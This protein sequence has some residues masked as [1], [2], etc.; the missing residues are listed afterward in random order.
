M[1]VSHVIALNQGGSEAMT[2][3]S[4]SHI[5]DEDQSRV[6]SEQN[7]AIWFKIT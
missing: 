5:Q 1:A 7:H 2:P 6:I 3:P 4:L